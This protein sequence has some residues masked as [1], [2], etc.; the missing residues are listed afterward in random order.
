M[1]ALTPAR[2][3]HAAQ[4]SPLPLSRRPNI[5]SPTTLWAPGIAFAVASAC[6]V[7]SRD[8]GFAMSGQARRATPPK[9][10]RYPTGCSFA[11]G[12][13]PPR[14]ATTQLPSATCVTTSHRLDFHLPDKTTSRTHPPRQSRGSPAYAREVLSRAVLLARGCEV[15]VHRHATCGV[16]TDTR[17]RL[18]RDDPRDTTRTLRRLCALGLKLS[19]ASLRIGVGP[20]R[21]D[22]RPGVGVYSFGPPAPTGQPELHHRSP[23]ALA[24]H[25]C[26]VREHVQLCGPSR[27]AAVLLV[28]GWGIGSSG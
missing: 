21:A 8:Q 9:R 7:W 16:K 15:R 11:S 26:I 3:A 19:L 12:C 17:S 1:R 10:V 2:L 25:C 27:M 23:F 24:V 13:S 18:V 22:Q 14:L 4:V 6:S 20:K 28:R 5:L